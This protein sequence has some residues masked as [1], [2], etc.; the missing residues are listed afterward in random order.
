M[1]NEVR[2]T[3][4][5]GQQ[6]T[7]WS[8]TWWWPGGLGSTYYSKLQSATIKRVDM[9]A[10]NHNLLAVRTTVEGANRFTRLFLAGGETAIGPGLGTLNLPGRGKE[11]GVGSN[12]EGPPDQ[13]RAAIH[14]E[15]VKA[16]QRI[17]LRYLA[18]FPDDIS[19]T[20]NPTLNKTPGKKWWDLFAAW[21]LEMTTQGWAIKLLDKGTAFPLSPV[22]TYRLRAAAPSVLGVVISSAVPFTHTDGMRVALQGVRMTRRGLESPNGTW[23]IDG[24]EVDVPTARRTIWLRGTEGFDP[25]T[26]LTLGKVRAVQ[27]GFQLPDW[28]EPIRVGIHKRGKPFGSPV[29]RRPTR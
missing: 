18:G 13:V 28:L 15:V 3:W 5:F 4:Y 9:L 25:T 23:V 16:G 19:L 6:Q 26:F 14:M 20:E 1:A 29:G 17:G 27:H 22:I 24:I 10:P 2:T 12:V 11:D 8:E 21:R 7:G